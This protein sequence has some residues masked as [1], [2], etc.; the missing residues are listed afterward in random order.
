ML[1]RFQTSYEDSVAYFD[2]R[3]GVD[4]DQCEAFVYEIRYRLVLRCDAG[5]GPSATLSRA[6]PAPVNEKALKTFLSVFSRRDCRFEHKYC[7]GMCHAAPE[8]V[9]VRIKYMYVGLN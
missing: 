5:G 3:R 2:M 6:H 1:G 8:D 7:G 4:A 9:F